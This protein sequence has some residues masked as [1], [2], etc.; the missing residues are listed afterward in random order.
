VPSA[1]TLM[2][3]VFAQQLGVAPQLNVMLHFNPQFRTIPD[4]DPTAIIVQS[5]GLFSVT[6]IPVPAGESES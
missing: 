3:G 2:L 5:L 4:F 6:V 1:V